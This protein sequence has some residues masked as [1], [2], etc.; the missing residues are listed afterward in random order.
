MTLLEPVGES[1]VRGAS[2]PGAGQYGDFLTEAGRVKAFRWEGR[3]AF[4]LG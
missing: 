3:L 4:R 1:R 2:G